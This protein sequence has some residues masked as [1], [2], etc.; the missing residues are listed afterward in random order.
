MGSN[1]PAKEEIFN[2]ALTNQAALGSAKSACF[3]C[4]EA[5]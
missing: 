5:T 3:S 4:V 2:R 1:W